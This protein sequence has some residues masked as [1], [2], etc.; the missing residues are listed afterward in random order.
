[1]RLQA[2]V[3][4]NVGLIRRTN[5]D[6]YLVRRGLYAVC[7]GMGGARAGE[8]ASEMAVQGL[9]AIEPSTL[10]GA[11]LVAVV[12]EI[13]DAIFARSREDATLSGMGT[14][15]T[16]VLAGDKRLTLVH[17]GDSR[18]YLLRDGHL[19]QLTED[20]SWVGE[21]IRRGE[22]TPAEAAI[23]PHRSVITKALGTELDMEPDLVEVDVEPGDRLLLCSDGLN[24]MV[25]DDA[26]EEALGR[27]EGPQ[28]VAEALVKAA[29]AGGG[30][31]NVT[32]VVVDVASGEEWMDGPVGGEVSALDAEEVGSDE[33][34]PAEGAH[35]G[36][37]AVDVE[38]PET[39][40]TED[41]AAPVGDEVF[42]GPS[43]RGEG[44]VAL[45]RTAMR[46]PLKGM[47]A[48][49]RGR[50]SSRL[51]TSAPRRT[52]TPVAGRVAETAGEVSDGTSRDEPSPERPKGSRR[53]RW[54]IVAVVVVVIVVAISGFAIFNSSV[55]YVGTHEG[56]VA[57]YNGLS[58]SILGIDLSSVIE[59]STV[60]Y[61]SLP[62][63]I[64][65]HIDAHEITSK[66]EGQRYLRTL[67]VLR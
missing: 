30:E 62:L 52:Q 53:R 56:T 37:G 21:M 34:D 19:C 23:H 2:G 59:E 7:D 36:A 42:L 18:A 67:D 27:D 4:S 60:A 32:V 55:Y 64:Q 3:A 26:I 1:M 48:A 14:T 50:L 45:S 29:L 25:L 46:G 20:H 57:L 13:N 5:E 63:H 40:S 47:R 44:D 24:G 39:G 6:S 38:S 17:V 31:D 51:A 54:I 10:D 12:K 22:L 15:L 43:D 58:G 41:G 28:E 33:V 35:L 11:G 9:A 49:A 66:K 8:V 16:V 61:E 65:A